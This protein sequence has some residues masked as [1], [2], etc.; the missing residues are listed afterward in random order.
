MAVLVALERVARA[1]LLAAE[2]Q[3]VDAVRHTRTTPEAGEGLRDLHI[4]YCQAEPRPGGGA[5]E[6]V[7]ATIPD[8]LQRVLNQG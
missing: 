5:P 1:P 3:L 7:N 6:P 2:A 8:E 4:E